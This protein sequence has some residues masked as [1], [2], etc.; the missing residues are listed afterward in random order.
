MMIKELE[1]IEKL[2][3]MNL[4]M[5]FGQDLMQCSLLKVTNEFLNEIC[6]A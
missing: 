6:V 4:G 3:D 2:R 1:L 5:L